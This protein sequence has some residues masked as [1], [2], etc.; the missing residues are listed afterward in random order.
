[1]GLSPGLQ[2][3]QGPGQAWILSDTLVDETASSISFSKAVLGQR[4]AS[5]ST[6]G[7]SESSP[8]TSCMAGAAPTRSL[9]GLHPGYWMGPYWV[10]LTLDID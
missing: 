10:E 6:V 7:S 3:Y 2:Y 8:I 9:V 1:M 5:G 4:S